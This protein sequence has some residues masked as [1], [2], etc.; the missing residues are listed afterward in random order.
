[1]P[2]Q[3]QSMQ[4]FTSDP[5]LPL[6]ELGPHA[7]EINVNLA[8]STTFTKGTVMGQVGT[9][10]TND[11]Q[12]ITITGTPTGGSFTMTGVNPLTGVTFTTAAIAY[13]AAASAVQTELTKAANYGSGNVTCGGGPLPGST[14][15]VTGA[16]SLK[17]VPLK[18]LTTTDSLTGGSTPASSVA[19]TTTGRTAL[20]WAAYNDGNSD[21]TQTAKGI[22]KYTCTTDA[23]GNIS[24]ST[25]AN[26]GPWGETFL[27]TPVYIAGYFNCADLTGLDSNGVTDLGRLVSGTSSAG[28][29]KVN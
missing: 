3:M 19:H 9:A 13:N 25:S 6:V 8:P 26:G 15:T 27:S 4:D 24:Y 5:L 16:G 11:V 23:M 18:L 22:M 2:P 1:M 28:I 20:T 12:T 17:N 10:S 29:L 21:G 7:V 14:V